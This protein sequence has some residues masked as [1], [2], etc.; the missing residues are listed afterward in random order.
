MTWSTPDGATDRRAPRHPRWYQSRWLFKVLLVSGAP[1]AVAAAKVWQPVSRR[2]LADS[3]RVERTRADSMLREV[4]EPLRSTNSL[5][6]Y[7][8]QTTNPRMLA[9]AKATNP[10]IRCP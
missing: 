1:L 6:C 2:E 5:L 4:S 8:A 9:T 7:L 3:L 10:S